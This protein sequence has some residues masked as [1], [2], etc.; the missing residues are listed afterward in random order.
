MSYKQLIEVEIKWAESDIRFSD[1]QERIVK[2]G[3][4]RLLMRMYKAFGCTYADN[5]K[6]TSIPNEFIHNGHIINRDLW[7]TFLLLLKEYCK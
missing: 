1:W 2:A 4:V 7:L 3:G 5:Y 6:Q